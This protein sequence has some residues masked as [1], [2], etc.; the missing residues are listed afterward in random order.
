[1]GWVAMGMVRAFSR[2]SIRPDMNALT[3]GSD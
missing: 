3:F 2:L 1:M